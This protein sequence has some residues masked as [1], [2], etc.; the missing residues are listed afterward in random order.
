MRLFYEAEFSPK[1]RLGDD[2][3]DTQADYAAELGRSIETLSAY[4]VDDDTELT[5]INRRW[6]AAASDAEREDI[7]ADAEAAGLRFSPCRCLGAW[8]RRGDAPP[9]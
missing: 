4:A 2:M 7:A 1:A 9:R 5:D 8:I 3:S 6:R